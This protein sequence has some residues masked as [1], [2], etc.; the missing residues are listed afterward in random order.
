MEYS[1]LVGVYE[2]LSGTSKLLEKRSIISEFLKSLDA[3]EVESS[4]LLLEGRLF[5][6]VDRR[7]IGI[8]TQTV[9]KAISTSS[10]KDEISLKNDWAKIGDLGKVA[11]KNI[12]SKTQSTLFSGKLTIDQVFNNLRKLSEIEGG[13]STS[14]KVGLISEL[15]GASEGSEAKY[16]V[17]TCL[18]DLR[19]GAG[20]G[21]LRDAIADAF[22]VDVSNVQNAYDLT[23]DISRV[24]KV[25]RTKGDRGLKS[26]ELNVG[27]PVSYAVQK[28]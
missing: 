19:T 7:K 16:I 8:G 9:I 10:G 21:V 17:R 11:E 20:F 1:K 22:E 14:K 18:E 4:V 25:A 13:G 6:E 12:S 15:L 3:R 5:P 27:T 23:T 28:V 24:S 26:L 2:A